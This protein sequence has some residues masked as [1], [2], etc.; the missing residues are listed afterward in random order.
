MAQPGKL[1]STLLALEILTA[2]GLV[3][4]PM[5]EHSI[6]KNIGKFEWPKLQKFKFVHIPKAAGTS[7]YK[8]G[9]ANSVRPGVV[10]T[11]G[12]QRLVL[13]KNDTAKDARAGRRRT[14][15]TD[16]MMLIKG[17]R[18]LGLCNSWHIPP[19]WRN[20][21]LVLKPGAHGFAFVRD[22]FERLVSQALFLRMPCNNNSLPRYIHDHVAKAS[23]P[24]GYALNDCH[25]IPQVDYLHHRNG[26]P[27]DGLMPI[28]FEDLAEVMGQV[29]PG[30]SFGV[31]A[32]DHHGCHPRFTDETQKLIRKYYARD[33]E[34]RKVLCP[35]AR[36]EKKRQE[37]T[38]PLEGHG[39]KHLGPGL[40]STAALQYVIKLGAAGL[41][42][43]QN[44]AKLAERLA[45]GAGTM[46]SA[47]SFLT[48]PKLLLGVRSLLVR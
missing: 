25:Y 24:A 39:G 38:P 44:E 29:F 15:K 18:R 8:F 37:R 1:I 17:T 36:L 46:A 26:T 27:I 2:N 13:T 42:S 11:W 5:L 33:F 47:L 21:S 30:K 32:W 34:M 22:P 41:I 3:T 16:K 28:C 12:E 6:T 35:T 45:S 19:R 31:H 40:E 7:V 23:A 43:E 14:R 10:P 4:A 9:L 48:S 20:K